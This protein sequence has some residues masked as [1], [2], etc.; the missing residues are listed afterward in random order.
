MLWLKSLINYLFEKLNI[1]IIPSPKHKVRRLTLRRCVPI[2]LI[3]III[4]SIA[5]LSY[6]YK[7]Y[8]ENYYVIQGKVKELRGVRAENQKLKKELY[9]LVQDTEELKNKVSQ[10]K[11]YNAEIKNMINLENEQQANKE[12]KHD[13]KLYTYIDKNPSVIQQGLPI[14]GGEI[15]LFYQQPE[16]AIEDA[17]DNI[18]VLKDELPTQEED[19]NSLESSVEKYNN[20]QAATPK[21][22]PLADKGK[23]YVSSEFGW[24]TDPFSGKQQM[25]EGLDLAT[26][27]NTPVLATADG[28][29][30]YTGYKGGYGRMVVIKHGYGYKTK[31]AHLNKIL[32]K[33]GQE[34]SRE[35][36]IAL[37]GN[38]GKSNGPHLHYEVCINN[39]SKNP[40]KYIGR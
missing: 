29:I 17:K 26:W 2:I 35:D 7:F 34:V 14:G 1:A 15:S 6:L 31:Y 19:L 3:I 32:V 12:E 9:T 27:Y 28:V 18:S 23:A 4:T 38:S 13:L 8:H 25:H 39:I 5:M 36:K 10:L 20:L 22:W 11:E 37:S 16:G 30:E 21:I 33:E 24:R 40:R